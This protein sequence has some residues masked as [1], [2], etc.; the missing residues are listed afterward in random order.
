MSKKQHV[1]GVIAVTVLGSSL[2][3]A[4]DKGKKGPPPPMSFFVT[5]VG[6][7]KGANLGGLAGAD[8]LCQMRAASAGQR[9]KTGQ[10]PLITPRPG[11]VT[12]RERLG[13]GPRH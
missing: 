13:S 4:Q 12:V 5:S 3:V 6:S 1:F 7:G 8:Q 10:A 2:A 11:G 9:Q